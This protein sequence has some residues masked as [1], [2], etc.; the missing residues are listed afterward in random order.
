[1]LAS[2]VH[3]VLNRD[4]EEIRVDTPH[5][6]ELLAF[7]ARY[8]LRGEVRTDSAGDVITLLGEPDMGRVARLITDWTDK[9]A[10]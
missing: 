10:V 2:A 6:P 5:G 1:M 9:H 3:P 7:L 4:R 8:K